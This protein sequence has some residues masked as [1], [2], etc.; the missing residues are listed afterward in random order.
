MFSGLFLYSMLFILACGL[1]TLLACQCI[2][3]G[4]DVADIKEWKVK[5]KGI[6]IV[7]IVVGIAIGVIGFSRIFHMSQ[8][9]T[10]SIKAVAECAANNHE[11]KVTNITNATESEN[12]SITYTCTVCGDS[13]TVETVPINHTTKNAAKN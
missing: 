8:S 1:I 9:Y 3:I 10:S 5:G 4:V 6:G 7:I 13:Y 11:Y 2:S 12:G